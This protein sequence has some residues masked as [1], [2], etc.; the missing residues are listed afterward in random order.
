MFTIP[1]MLAIPVGFVALVFFVIIWRISRDWGGLS[2]ISWS[3]RQTVGVIQSVT[4]TGERMTRFYLGAN[5]HILKLGLLVTP[6]DGGAPFPA[7]AVCPCPAVYVTALVPG[8][9][10]RVLLSKRGVTAA[11]DWATLPPDTTPGLQPPQG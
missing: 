7:E 6:L 11:P 3:A 5:A 2:A 8:L 10:I 4:D 9:P 1:L